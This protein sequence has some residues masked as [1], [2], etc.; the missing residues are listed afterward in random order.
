MATYYVHSTAGSNSWAGTSASPWRTIAFATQTATTGDT[1]LLKGGSAAS[2][3]VVYQERVEISAASGCDSGSAGSPIT[4]SNNPGEY[5]ELRGGGSGTTAMFYVNARRYW[6]FYFGGSTGGNFYALF[7]LQDTGS[8]GHAFNFT[9]ASNCAL[10]GADITNGAYDMFIDVRRSGSIS[11]SYNRIYDNNAGSGRD[12]HGIQIS[13]V[14]GDCNDIVIEY[15]TIY[16]CLGDCVQGI[17]RNA[18]TYQIT[19]PIVRYNT[20]YVQSASSN[21]A[22][23]G[24]DFKNC[25]GGSV[26]NNTMYGFRYCSGSFGGTGGGTRG[27]DA[28]QFHDDGGSCAFYDNVFYDFSGA[29]ISIPSL[30]ASCRADF[31]NNLIYDLPT[32][33]SPNTPALFYIAAGSAYIYNNTVYGKQAASGASAA[34][35]LA[36]HGATSYAIVRNNIFYG[37]GSITE[38]VGYVRTYDYNAWYNADETISGTGDVTTDPAFYNAASDDYRLSGSSPCINAASAVSPYTTGRTYGASP[39]IGY[40]EYGPA[41]SL[42]FGSFPPLGT[43][44]SPVSSFTVTATRFDGTTDTAYASSIAVYKLTGGGT[45][46]GTTTVYPTSGVSTFSAVTFS[47]AGDY[48]LAASAGS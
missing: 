21:G 24:V 13:P 7:D 15:N 44:G 43:T 2:A 46:G 26:H 30:S 33:D 32:R 41:S 5:I 38:D 3:R 34:G 37:S 39:D 47:T 28:I 27:G 40:Y 36:Y 35:Q 23:N 18:S 14:D 12:A 1:I 8:Q 48:T 45:V 16:D 10:S 19:R 29:V 20:F 6:N 42:T 11:I 4:V 22:E 25:F 9:A 17:V 31:Y